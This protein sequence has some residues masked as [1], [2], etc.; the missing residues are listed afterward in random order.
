MGQHLSAKA[1]RKRNTLTNDLRDELGKALRAG[2]LSEA[3]AVCELIEKRKPD[4][5]R[6]PRR[7]ADLL[8]RMGREDD[9]VAA[10]Q[11]AI[12]LYAAKGFID[13]AI[14]T[15]KV[16]LSID[17]TKMAV[18]NRLE[19][20]ALSGVHQRMFVMTHADAHHRR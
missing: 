14:A 18:L 15:A 17:P 1:M 12:E 3:L 16:M 5:P 13:R 10:Y 6:W 19:N 2:R 8:N 11:Q 4:E 7:R 9:A 20:E